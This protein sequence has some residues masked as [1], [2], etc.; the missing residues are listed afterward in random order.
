MEE[1]KVIQSVEIEGRFVELVEIKKYLPFRE[2]L[3]EI[4]HYEIHLDN[5]IVA[6][7]RIPT[8]AETVFML[9]ISRLIDEEV[10][11]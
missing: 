1:K 2:E 7:T 11:I 5:K 3:K 9:L 8:L 6:K 10:Q 4:T